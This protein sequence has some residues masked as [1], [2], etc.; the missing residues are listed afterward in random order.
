MIAI[1]S[2]IIL[3]I[4]LFSKMLVTKYI[5][6]NESISVI[7]NFIYFTHVRNTGVAWSMFDESKYLVII[8][9]ALIILGLIVYIAKNKVSNRLEKVAYGFVL[10][11]ALGNFIGRCVKGYVTDFIDIKIFNY[12]YPIFNLA[13][14]FIVLG[15]IIFIIYTW[16]CNNGNKSKRRKPCKNR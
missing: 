1:I 8:I 2:I 10:G 16:R 13:D 5:S 7:N 4:D 6:L 11:G 3:L 9:S 15:V 12:D 14:V